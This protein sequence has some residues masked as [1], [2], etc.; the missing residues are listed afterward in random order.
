LPDWMFIW[1][2]DFETVRDLAFEHVRKLVARYRKAVSLWNVAAGLATN[3]AFTLTFDQMTELTRLLVMQVK[4]AIPNARTLVTITQPFG[5]YLAKS[6]T[7]V[8]PL[9]YADTITQAGITVDAFA[10][11]LEMGVPQHGMWMRDLFQISALLDRLATLNRPIFITAVVAPGR[12]TPDPSDRSE[13]HMDPAQAGRWRRDWD[14][15]LQ[16]DW[17]EAVYQVALSKPFVESVAWSDLADQNQ[18]V[19]GGGLL[20]DMFQPKPAFER[21]QQLRE[22]FHGWHARKQ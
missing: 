21:L 13:G 7:S 17:M 4:N 12:H 5:E 20:D 8:S 22:R 3:R 6:P 16:A 14:P 2:N 19:P 9:F 15:M 18:T 1:E 10:L 11:E